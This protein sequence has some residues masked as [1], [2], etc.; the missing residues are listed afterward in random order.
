MLS[1]I[2]RVGG[3]PTKPLPALQ[4]RKLVK[5]CFQTATGRKP[6]GL[7]ELDRLGQEAVLSKLARHAEHMELGG[8][9][10][11]S[12]CQGRW[13]PHSS[14]VR[15]SRL[16]CLEDEQWLI[17]FVV[18]LHEVMGGTA[19]G[20]RQRLSAIRYAH[21]AAGFPD[22]LQGRVRLRAS[23]QGLSR[24]ESAPLRKVPVTPSIIC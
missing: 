20:I 6:V 13:F 19:Q 4:R 17:Q 9:I 3:K 8:N 5:P 12:S 15:Q 16:E 24:W 11:N 2:A 1:P 18:F 22:P 10:G 21:I 14:E 7:S 23:L